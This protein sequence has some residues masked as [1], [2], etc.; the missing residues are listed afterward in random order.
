MTKTNEV[1]E[2]LD[3]VIA[4]GDDFLG[5]AK[6]FIAAVE[7]LLAVLLNAFGNFSATCKKKRA[8]SSMI[9]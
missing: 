1:S 6:D 5:K 7:I 8:R 9:M 4:K 3:N 2:A